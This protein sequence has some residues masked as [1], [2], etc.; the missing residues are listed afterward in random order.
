MKRFRFRSEA[1]HDIEEIS[2]KLFALNPA[3]ASRFLD[4][5]DNL[6]ELLAQHSELGRPRPELGQNLRSVPHGNYLVFYVPTA[7]GIDVIRVVYGG[8]NLPDLFVQM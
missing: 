8:R 6:C 7:E 4:T 3:A 2:N 1:N 5:L